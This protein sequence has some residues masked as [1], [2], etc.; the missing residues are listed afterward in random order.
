MLAASIFLSLLGF[1]HLSMTVKRH[2]YELYKVPPDTKHLGLN[3]AIGW[4]L[5]LASIWPCL[6]IWPT[7]IAL[8]LWVGTITVSAFA[9]VAGL[10]YTPRIYYKVWRWVCIGGWLVSARRP[11]NQP[12]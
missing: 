11:T 9:V 12:S 4:L 1:M 7:P 3:H 5:L 8:T 6:Y 10:S 2:F